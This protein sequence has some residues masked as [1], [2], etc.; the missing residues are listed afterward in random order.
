MKR[1]WFFG[2]LAAGCLAGAGLPA[3]AQND[4]TEEA[5]LRYHEAIAVTARCEDRKFD[6]T[7][8]SRMA[9]YIDQTVQNAIGA[10]RR[11]SLI[12]LAKSNAYDL[13]M[14]WTCKGDKVMER[15]SLFDQE[16]RPLL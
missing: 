9:T 16:L 14:K 4:A 12:E 11:L 1:N 6:D 8:H 15:R 7:E 3:A 10:G 5:Y 13:V 2:L